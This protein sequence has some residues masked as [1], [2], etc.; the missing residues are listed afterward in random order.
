MVTAIVMEQCATIPHGGGCQPL[1][2]RSYLLCPIFDAL[3]TFP[4]RHEIK[5]LVRVENVFRIDLYNGS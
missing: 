3:D 5:A 4:W 2:E 1:S